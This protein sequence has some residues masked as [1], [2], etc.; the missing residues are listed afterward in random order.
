MQN[1]YNRRL[2]LSD[3]YLYQDVYGFQLSPD[4]NRWLYV[5]QVDEIVEERAGHGALGNLIVKP[6]ADLTMLPV[7]RG[8]PQPL[9]FTHLPVS[10]PQWSPDGTSIAFG[11]GRGLWTASP[12]TGDSKLIASDPVSQLVIHEVIS[13][14][15][16]LGIDTLW[17][18]VLWSPT[19]THLLY[20]TE[21]DGDQSLW[22]IASD[23][24]NKFRLHVVEGRIFSRQWSPDG[25][26]II[27]T[28]QE[29]ESPNT[30]K[31]CLLDVN[32]RQVQSLSEVPHCF[33]LRPLAAFVPDGSRIIFRSNR[34][35]FA[36]LWIMTIDGGDS[37]Q[38]TH[39]DWDDSV[40]CISP[41][42][43]RVAVASR[44][45]QAGGED[46][47]LVRPSGGEANRLTIQRGLNRPIAWAPDGQ[48]LYYFHSSP[49]EPGD[50]WRT[51]T[52]ADTSAPVTSSRSQWLSA[53]LRWPEEMMVRGPEGDIYTLVF[54]PPD[55]DPA[56]VYPAIV[57]IKGGP[58]TSSRVAY[59]PEAQWLAEQ[60]YVVARPNYRGS[61]GFGVAHMESGAQGNAGLTDLEDI[62]AV[63]E[64]LKSLS[65]VDESRLGVMGRS[66]G[67]YM[68]LMAI[69]QYPELFRC[70]VAHAAIYNWSVQ[71]AEE[72]CRQ[73][74]H[75]LY[76]GWV[77]ED[78]DLYAQRS[79]ITF[80]GK[81]QTPLL[82]THGRN[83]Q[84][85]PF[86]QVDEFVSRARAAGVNIT[87]H[88]YEDEGHNNKR[89]ENRK[90]YLDR[91]L[92]FLATY[93]KAWDFRT[94]PRR[95]QRLE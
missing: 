73:Y 56:R 85:V 89:T 84:N 5:T 50:L 95:G 53:K 66:W 6:L 11:G 80:V 3:L 31:I 75:W 49:V 58:T 91:T 4:G 57:W 32:T 19:G 8:Y 44:A 62:H 68:T 63:A 52:E 25:R 48:S 10:P 20:V 82:I 93:L 42:G 18:D 59:E 43:E 24:S 77:N 38:L 78:V 34:S 69:A 92:Q 26:H 7:A 13:P 83:D 90:D 40:F 1:S 46:L 54:A 16:Q 33:Y 17:A 88:Y 21:D 14:T 22:L 87:A 72:D 70:A 30:G 74:S 29:W 9:G 81:V 15:R 64:Y 2:E 60:G 35:G 28:A 41:D 94:T 51:D 37:R 71:Q 27:F 76:G 39:G 61:I 79:P 65:Y 12:D 23:G 55:F 86:A 45:D 47:W 36:K 67:G